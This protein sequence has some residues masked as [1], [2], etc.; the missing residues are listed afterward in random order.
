M[1]RY[2]AH[3]FHILVLPEYWVLTENRIPL[4]PVLGGVSIVALSISSHEQIQLKLTAL[5]TV[6]GSDL[7]DL[8][9]RC[10]LG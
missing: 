2:S 3:N 5:K 10:F 1:H 7:N 9:I 6:K 4:K 8:A